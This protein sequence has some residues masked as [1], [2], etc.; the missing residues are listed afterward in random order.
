MF[1]H[2]MWNPEIIKIGFLSIR[3]YGLAYL[4]SILSIYFLGKKAIKNKQL[5]CTNKD[6]EE[7]I[8]NATLG[9]IIGGR[10]AYM[11]FYQTSEFLSSPLIFFKIWQG[12]MSFHG[13]ALGVLLA[14]FI[15]SRKH[16]NF[17]QI[18]DFICLYA[19]LGLFLGRFANFINGELCGRIAT[20]KHW[21]LIIYPWIDKNPRHPSQIYEM[22]G[23][24]VVLFCIL[25]LVSK[26]KPKPGLLSALFCL[27]YGLVRFFLEFFRE[28]DVQIGFIWHDWLTMGQALSL[29]MISVGLFLLCIVRKESKPC[30]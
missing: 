3:W 17:W 9:I 15:F 21:W 28:A 6:F 13:G 26:M 12:G 8:N 14:I 4:V 30:I 24:G 19:P 2:P 27:I 11:I 18:S 7:L 25:L 20:S 16:K 22:I 23:E 1:V 10:L 5:S 29:A